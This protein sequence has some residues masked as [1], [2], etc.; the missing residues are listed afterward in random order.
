VIFYVSLIFWSNWATSSE[1]DGSIEQAW[2]DGTHRTILVPNLGWPIG[3][4]IDSDNRYLYWLDALQFTVQRIKI[5]LDDNQAHKRE[6]F[7]SDRKV[8][9]CLLKSLKML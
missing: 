7:D 9:L 3:L 8:F 6:V 1:K 5:G 4:T 2:M